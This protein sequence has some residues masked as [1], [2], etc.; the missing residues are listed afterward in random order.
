MPEPDYPA[1]AQPDH[2][3]KTFAAILALEAQL[4]DTD[5]R[6]GAATIEIEQRSVFGRDLLYPVGLYGAAVQDLTKSK[7]I[8]RRALN[9]LTALG[10]SL[11]C[12]H[13]RRAITRDTIASAGAICDHGA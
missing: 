6:D 3:L 1:D 10:L 13:C 7:T 8:D 2:D 9:C 5:Q 11:R 4:R 12:N